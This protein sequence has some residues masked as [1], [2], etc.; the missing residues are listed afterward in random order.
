MAKIV[1]ST[2]QRMVLQSGSTTLT[3]DK[4]ADK[5]T[6][7][8]KLLFVVGKGGVGK[9]AVSQALAL[10]LSRRGK[11]TLWICFEDPTL[12]TDE[13]IRRKRQDHLDVRIAAGR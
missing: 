3:L 1:E 8:R 4:S 7:Q 12:P 13:F 9:T 2:P 5:A 10:S 6:M 11:K